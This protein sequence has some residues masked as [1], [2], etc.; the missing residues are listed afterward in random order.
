MNMPTEKVTHKEHDHIVQRPN[1]T[2][3][4]DID[5]VEETERVAGGTSH[6]AS[7]ISGTAP[8]E[9]VAEIGTAPTMATRINP[10]TGK[11]LSIPKPLSLTPQ[12]MS[13]IVPIDQGG[14]QLIRE[15]H[16]EVSCG[17]LDSDVQADDRP[18]DKPL[19]ELLSSP[20]LPRGHSLDL[21]DPMERLLPMYLLL[22]E[23]AIQSSATLPMSP[24]PV[25]S[26]PNTSLLSK[27]L[28]S[29]VNQP[30]RS[31]PRSLKVILPLHPSIPRLPASPRLPVP[32]RLL[33][34][35]I[36]LEMELDHLQTPPTMFLEPVN[37]VKLLSRCTIPT[38][39]RSQRSY[40]SLRTIMSRMLLVVVLLV[41]LVHLRLL[42][43]N[44]I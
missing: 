37:L 15:E 35:P 22:L 20:R 9:S 17:V 26:I 29:M 12:D 13:P 5:I 1:G 11:A 33:S 21:L 30:P 39:R 25:L 6:P 31:S 40:Q 41:H 36:L 8:L 28:P 32:S 34:L 24:T 42:W 19:A 16:E 44:R 2:I 38:I 10:R 3:V 4:E 23:A 18:F 27:V 7:H 43:S 14:G